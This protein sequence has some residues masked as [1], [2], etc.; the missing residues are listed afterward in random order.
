MTKLTGEGQRIVADIAERYGISVDAATHM[1]LAVAAGHG[2]QAQFNHPDFG[3]MGQW[4]QGGMTMVGDMFNNGL[5]AQVSN[6]CSELSGIVQSHGLF[7]AP[8]SSQSQS[9]GA[10]YAVSGV[11]L[12]VPSAPDWPADLGRP[13]SVGA[14]ND[15][16]YAY[17]PDT[18]RLA[19]DIGGQITVYDTLDHRISGFGQAQSGGQSLSFTSQHGLVSVASLPTVAAPPVTPPSPAKPASEPAVTGPPEE[20]AQAAP[21]D[22]HIPA[23]AP[24]PTVA[25]PAATVDAATTDD[26]IFGKIERLADLYD[27]GIL[28]QS[29][30]ETK[31]AELLARL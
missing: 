22:A 21:V 6:L 27:K 26:Q 8:A 31:K 1:L 17:F 13:A 23:A 30:F 25:P 20:P 10:G 16:R 14:Q 28:S 7:P 12:F 19:I 3:G 5:K 9:Q 4:S 18:R 29:E 24:A 11:S 15:M 2:T